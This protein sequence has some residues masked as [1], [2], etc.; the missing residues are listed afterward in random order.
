MGIIFRRLD[1]GRLFKVSI[2]QVLERGTARDYI[3]GHILE[4]NLYE[5]RHSEDNLNR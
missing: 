1:Y 5:R 2:R 3:Q 4:L